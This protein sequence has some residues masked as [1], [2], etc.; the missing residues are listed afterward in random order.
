MAPLSIF[1]QEIIAIK[2]KLHEKPTLGPFW[3][4]P[5]AQRPILGPFHDRP[6]RT[7]PYYR[8]GARWRLICPSWLRCSD[9]KSRKI[10]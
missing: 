2:A 5:N 6:P 3:D 4:P 1:A 8:I 9:A 7:S 10:G